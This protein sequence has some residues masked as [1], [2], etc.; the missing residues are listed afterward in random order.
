MSSQSLSYHP[1]PQRPKLALPSGACDAHVHVF[2][3]QSRGTRCSCRRRR[4]R[5]RSTRSTRRCARRSPRL[6][7][8]R[9]CSRA[10]R[11]LRRQRLRSWGAAQTRHRKVGQ[12]DQGAEDYAGGVGARVRDCYRLEAGV[13]RDA[14]KQ[15]SAVVR[16]R[17]PR[18][19]AVHIVVR[20]NSHSEMSRK[21]KRLQLTSADYLV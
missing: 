8:A 4:F 10:A 5:P 19:W 18:G 12:T 17:V 3:P 14:Q 6:R 11:C 13:R 2:G 1:S 21:Y 15:S 9:S 7:L 20:L 16:R